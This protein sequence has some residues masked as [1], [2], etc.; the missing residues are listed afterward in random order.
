MTNLT[1]MLS[2][3]VNSNTASTSGSGT[4]PSNTITNLK[5]IK[6]TVTP[7]NNG[8]TK[9]VQPPVVQVQPQVPNS[10]PVVAP[11]CAPMPN[12]KPSIPYPSRLNDQ[13]IREKANNQI[14]KFYQ[15]FQDLHF[16]ISFA[17]A[18]IL[19]PKFASTLKSLISNKEKLFELARTPLNEHCLAVLLKKLS[20]KLGR[21][22]R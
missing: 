8:S 11:V 21:S 6:D 15:I 9:Y 1:N 17:D 12:P 14:E 2:K 22:W 5:V 10:E 13:K 4:L 20:E 16:D 3:F 18:L 7:T 19:M